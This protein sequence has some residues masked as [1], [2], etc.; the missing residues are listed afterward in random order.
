MTVLQIL[1]VKWLKRPI[2]IGSTSLNISKSKL[3]WKLTIRKFSSLKLT[4]LFTWKYFGKVFKKK[5]KREFYK[6]HITSR[7]WYDKVL[8]ILYYSNKQC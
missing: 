2:Q 1:I 8:Q 5:K 7:D 3:T 6:M 4:F